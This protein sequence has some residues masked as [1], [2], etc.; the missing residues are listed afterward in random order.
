MKSS[1]S[2]LL[3]LAV[4]LLCLGAANAQEEKPEGKETAPKSPEP[5]AQTLRDPFWPIGYKPKAPEP[6]VKADDKTGPE[7]IEQRIKWPNLKLK[8]ITKA[9]DGSYIAILEGIGIVEA[10]DVIRMRQN[11]LIYRWKI[12][13]ITEKGVS[14]TQLDV[15]RAR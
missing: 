13:A 2:I 4:C 14:H 6:K 7:I 3:V 12:N 9:L 10:G 5:S 1:Y 8:G 11:N 15:R